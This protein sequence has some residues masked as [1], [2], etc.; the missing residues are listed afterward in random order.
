MYSY[1]LYLLQHTD[2]PKRGG[3]HYRYLPEL[4]TVYSKEYAAGFPEVIRIS[5]KAAYSEKE[6]A[7]E[8]RQTVE[9]Y[10]DQT[11]TTIKKDKNIWKRFQ[12]YWIK[13]L[14]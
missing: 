11:L 14:Y 3:S 10:L 1:I 4:E 13:S 6:I 2:I 12:M 5:Q 7:L 9:Q 8:E